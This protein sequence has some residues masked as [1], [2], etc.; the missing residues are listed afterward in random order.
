VRLPLLIK[1]HFSFLVTAR[2]NLFDPRTL[3]CFN[4]DKDSK[5]HIDL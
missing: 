1:I 3:S 5:V 2:G 4:K